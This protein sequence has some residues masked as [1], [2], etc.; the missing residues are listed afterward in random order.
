M[1]SGLPSIS[2]YEYD[3]AEEKL[4]PME[5]RGESKKPIR[6]HANQNRK[7]LASISKPYHAELSSTSQN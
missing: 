7:K 3:I 2:E 6:S 4:E 5:I 1:I